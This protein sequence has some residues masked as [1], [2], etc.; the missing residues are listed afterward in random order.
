MVWSMCNRERDD[1]EVDLAGISKIKF[2]CLPNDSKPSF[3]IEKLKLGAF[4]HIVAILA[5]VV[6]GAMVMMTVRLGPSS[7]CQIPTVAFPFMCSWKDGNCQKRF[8][9]HV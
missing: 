9:G 2:S 5:T 1:I 4:V 7:H 3:L 6:A 8:T